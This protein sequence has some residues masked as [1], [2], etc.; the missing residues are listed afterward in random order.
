MPLDDAAAVVVADRLHAAKVEEAHRTVGQEPVVARMWVGVEHPADHD[1]AVHEP[2]QR[3]GPC[4]PLLESPFRITREFAAEVVRR[5][6]AM[7]KTMIRLDRS[8]YA[9]MPEGILFLNRLQFGFYSVLARLDV[10]ADYASVEA[11]FLEAAREGL[12]G[13]PDTKVTPSLA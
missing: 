11:G 7:A 13:L 10:E 3:L 9:A 12:E 6:R 5:F 8:E 4:P 2:P 1:R